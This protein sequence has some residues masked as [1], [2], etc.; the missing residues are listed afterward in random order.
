MPRP[1]S[2]ELQTELDR[3]DAELIAEAQTMSTAE[4]ELKA[5]RAQESAVKERIRKLSA[6]RRKLG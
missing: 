1:I 6:L 4:A 2:P 5:I 3:L